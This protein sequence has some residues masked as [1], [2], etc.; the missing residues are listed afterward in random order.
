MR[1]LVVCQDRSLD[2]GL[3]G[4]DYLRSD[5]CVHGSAV[6]E[7][8]GSPRREKFGAHSRGFRHDYASK[9]ARCGVEEKQDGDRLSFEASL[10]QR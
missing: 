7:A 10:S 3:L 6:A 5:R 9:S 4:D 2:E 8:S 1:G